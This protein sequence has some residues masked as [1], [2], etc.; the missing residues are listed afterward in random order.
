[1]KKKSSKDSNA[2]QSG[3]RMMVRAIYAL[4]SL[5]T[6]TCAGGNAP[7]IT[8]RKIP[9]SKV[10]I[11]NLTH[12]PSAL[13]IRSADTK[14]PMISS[15]Y[16]FSMRGGG[17]AVKILPAGYNP[18][19]YGLTDLGKQFLTFNGSAESDVGKFLST[20]K[21]GRKTEATI[22]SQWLEIVRVSKKGQNMRIYRKLDELTKFCL[23]AGFID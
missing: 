7:F 4:L 2:H 9:C 10:T 6:V 23:S 14:S 19:G 17:A 21:S 11:Q 8:F 1:M 5:F 18:F 15:P 12:A 20:L 16:F 22:K 13:A 3:T